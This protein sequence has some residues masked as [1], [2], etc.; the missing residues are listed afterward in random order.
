MPLTNT[1]WGTY[2]VEVSDGRVTA[3]RPFSEDPDPSPIG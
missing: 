2:E 3:L 1:H